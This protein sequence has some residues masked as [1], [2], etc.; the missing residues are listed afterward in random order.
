MLWMALHV[1]M[2]IW[3]HLILDSVI[4][5][6]NIAN[7]LTR[8]NLDE[9]EQKNYSEEEMIDETG[10]S[11]KK[12]WTVGYL[13]SETPETQVHLPPK[14]KSCQT[15]DLCDRTD[16]QKVLS[17]LILRQLCHVHVRVPK[18][19]MSQAMYRLWSTY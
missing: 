12:L 16:Q 4:V 10:F 7:I 18:N 17:Q 9:E 6:R 3:W 11:L 1:H 8:L 2:H 15:A 14:L 13:L 19:E 5:A